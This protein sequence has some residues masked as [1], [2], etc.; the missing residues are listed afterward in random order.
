MGDAGK[1]RQILLNLLGNA[2]KFTNRGVVILKVAWNDGL[3]IFDVTDTGPGISKEDQQRLFAPFVQTAS[4]LRSGEGTGLGLALSRD[5]ARLLGGD[6]TV[7]SLPGQGATFR[8][9]LPL[10]EAS[11]EEL[12]GMALQEPRDV[13]SLAP[14]HPETRVLVADSV[15][16]GQVFL[17]TLLESAGF[18]VHTTSTSAETV[19]EWRRFRPHALIVDARLG[20][21]SGLSVFRTLRETEER[22]SGHGRPR[23]AILVTSAI[24]SSEDEGKVKAAGVDALLVKPLVPNEVFSRLGELLKLNYVYRRPGQTIRTDSRGMRVGRGSLH[25]LSSVLA[26]QLREALEAGDV[27]HA[28]KV[29]AQVSELKPALG[30]ELERLLKSYQFDLLERMAA[31]ENNP[32]DPDSGGI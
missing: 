8:F 9:S 19:E 30:A 18:L 28:K 17:R 20:G 11:P 23:M 1:M 14:G 22:E 10:P 21:I 25:S 13:E 26:K 15:Q 31:P 32:E 16:E 27:D 4:G 2:V 7:D 29:I 5:L 12:V 3:A 24:S 6:I